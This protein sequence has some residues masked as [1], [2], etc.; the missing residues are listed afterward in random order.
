MLTGR[1]DIVVPKGT[2]SDHVMDTILGGRCFR[3][4][5][6]TLGSAL[7]LDLTPLNPTLFP[8]FPTFNSHR[9][10][11]RLVERPFAVHFNWIVGIASKIEQMKKTGLWYIGD[12]V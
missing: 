1:F 7:E 5:S 3:Y 2:M 6:K 11:E 10:H 4:R 9:A 8:N 12:R